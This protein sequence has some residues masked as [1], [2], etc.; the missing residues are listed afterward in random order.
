MFLHKVLIP[1]CG[2]LCG[3]RVRGAWQRLLSSEAHDSASHAGDPAKTSC[4]GSALFQEG[5]SS[6]ATQAGGR[7]AQLLH[8]PDEAIV[9][10]HHLVCLGRPTL[11]QLGLDSAN[12]G[13]RLTNSSK[14]T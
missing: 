14:A 7:L 3:P 1:P 5:F 13:L 6:R 8:V 11:V 9:C 12:V 10:P 4:L 2:P